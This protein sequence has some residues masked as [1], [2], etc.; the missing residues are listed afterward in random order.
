MDVLTQRVPGI[1]AVQPQR[2]KLGRAP[3]ATPRRS[4]QRV[5]AEPSP[6]GRLIPE[7]GWVD[8]FLYQLTMFPHGAHDD[9]VDALT[10]LLVRCSF[11][12]R[13]GGMMH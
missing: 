5:P 1:V 8:G 4:G 12:Q 10:Q 3:T 9:D 13:A 2:S 11:T 6:H 7:R